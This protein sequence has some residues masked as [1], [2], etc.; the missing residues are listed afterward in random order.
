MNGNG[1][2]EVLVIVL[3]LKHLC[4]LAA[5]IRIVKCEKLMKVDLL[6]SLLITRKAPSNRPEIEF[7]SF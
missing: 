3:H 2:I 4:C 6:H 1:E 5:Q 7:S